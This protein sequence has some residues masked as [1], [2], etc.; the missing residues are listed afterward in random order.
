M[1]NEEQRN[2]TAS[3]TEGRW[4]VVSEPG[5]VIKVEVLEMTDE[6]RRMLTVDRPIY[7]PPPNLERFRRFW[8]L[9]KEA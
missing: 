7:L 6:I 8:N 2:R 4:R 1:N 5:A 9:P 3:L